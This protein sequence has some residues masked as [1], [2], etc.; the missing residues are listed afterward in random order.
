MNPVARRLIAI[1][2]GVVLYIGA[3]VGMWYSIDLLLHPTT[4]TTFVGAGALPALTLLAANQHPGTGTND[5]MIIEVKKVGK[6][7]RIHILDPKRVRISIDGHRFGA[8]SPTVLA[9]GRGRACLDCFKTCRKEYGASLNSFEL[10]GC[11][12]DMPRSCP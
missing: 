2:L 4:P 7:F 3:C 12:C 9:E 11:V 10:G 6:K 8:L 1:V 5:R